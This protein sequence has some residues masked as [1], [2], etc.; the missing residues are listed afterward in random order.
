MKKLFNEYTLSILVYLCTIIGLVII[1]ALFKGESF[2][3]FLKERLY[4]L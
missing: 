3:T 1:I 2:L 4:G